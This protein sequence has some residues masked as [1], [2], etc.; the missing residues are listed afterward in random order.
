MESATVHA[1]PDSILTARH[2]LTWTSGFVSSRDQSI[3]GTLIGNLVCVQWT[4]GSGSAAFSMSLL[5]RERVRFFLYCIPVRALSG[6]SS[7]DFSRA[8]LLYVI[9]IAATS[10]A[11]ALP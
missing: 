5:E 1:V 11:G 10:S 3:T 4:A 6:S 2:A 8:P 7:D 9:A